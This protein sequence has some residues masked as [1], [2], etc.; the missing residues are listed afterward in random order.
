MIIDTIKLRRV[1]GNKVSVLKTISWRIIGTLDTMCI[2]YFLTGKL[3]LALSIGGIEIISKMLL[4]YMHERA[5]V[6]LLNRN[7]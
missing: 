1:E 5:W 4:Y 3:E 2:S 6:K 7:S